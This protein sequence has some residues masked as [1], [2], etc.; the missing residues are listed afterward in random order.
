MN[1]YEFFTHLTHPERG[2]GWE[3]TTA[4]FTGKV[5][6]AAAGKPGRYKYKDYNEYEIRYYAG[7]TERR[8]WYTFYPV[9]DPEPEEI[10]GK[11]VRIRYSRIKPWIY[12]VMDEEELGNESE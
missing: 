8:G 2:K 6:R 10:Q 7:S 9:L 12:E 3:E 4:Y 1:L 5:E 11:E